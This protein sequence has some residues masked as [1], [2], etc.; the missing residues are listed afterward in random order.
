M[1]PFLHKGNEQ[2][3]CVRLAAF[4]SLFSNAGGQSFRI[5]LHIGL[6]NMINN[7]FCCSVN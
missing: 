1:L 3:L 2:S 7:V 4:A 6:Q 5:T